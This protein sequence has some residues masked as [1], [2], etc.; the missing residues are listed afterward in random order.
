MLFLFLICIVLL[1][2]AIIT[3]HLEL[4][5]DKEYSPKRME[6]FVRNWIKKWIPTAENEIIFASGFHCLKAMNQEID[7]LRNQL[8]AKP[9]LNIGIILRYNLDIKNTAPEVDKLIN[10]FNQRIEL[11]RL[12]KDFIVKQHYLIID[13]V[14]MLL[15]DHI[16]PL[17]K[18]KVIYSLP[19]NSRKAVQF[20]KQYKILKE[21]FVTAIK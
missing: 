2:I 11:K 5:H 12:K 10:E 7:I 3:I 17:D 19:N 14:T 15:S 6:G 8:I 21:E 13:G 1:L 16:H 9:N 18:A 4:K 20:K